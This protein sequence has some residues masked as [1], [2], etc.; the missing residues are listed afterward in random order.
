MIRSTWWQ[1]VNP[2]V[3]LQLL[4]LAVDHENAEDVVAD[5]GLTGLAGRLQT[6]LL[7]FGAGR[8][9]VVP[10]EE[11]VALAAAWAISPRWSGIP[12]AVMASM[13]RWTTGLP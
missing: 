7:V 12:R 11:S 5:F 6:P 1:Y 13:V 9:L 4:T 8:D 10:P 3:R 2:L